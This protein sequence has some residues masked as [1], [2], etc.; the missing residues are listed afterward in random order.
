ML[1]GLIVVDPGGAIESANAAAA[2]IFGRELKDMIGRHVT[3][4]LG[5]GPPDRLE[6]LRAEIRAPGQNRVTEFE[7][8]R[9]GGEL[10]PV[11][12]SLFEFAT[13]EG[14]HYAAS[15]RDL[16]GRREVE[17]LKKEFVAT[18]SHE[19][20]TPLTS[21]RGSLGLLASGVLGQLSDEAREVVGIAE[22]NTLRLITLINEILDLERLEAGRIEIRLANVAVPTLVDRSCE[23]VRAFADAQGVALVHA[24]V[25][26]TMLG[27]EDRLVQVL[28]NLL[29]NAV[30][31][32]ARGGIVT[33]SSEEGPGW[34]ELRVSDG[35]RGIPPDRLQDIFERFQQLEAT[36][37]REKGGT[38]L[39]LAIAKAIVDLHHGEIGVASQV[40]RGSTF[41]FC[42]PAATPSAAAADPLLNSLGDLPADAGPEVLLV[43]DDVPLLGVMARQLL[44]AGLAVRTATTAR[45]AVGLARERAPSLLVLDLGLPDGDGRSVVEALRGDAKLADTPLLA[46][47]GRDMSPG[48]LEALRLGP[49]LALV[50]SRSS[51]AEFLGLVGRLLGRDGP[52]LERA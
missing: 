31:F 16:S 37:A 18:V 21:V 50:K 44:G 38:G 35:G 15:I 28:V 33:V 51:D 6:A 45:Q 30:K 1:E 5:P 19:L 12:L 52:S 32:S 41:H 4:L 43:D 49:T 13:A 36:D 46:Y 8:Q 9:A 34:V 22:R 11:E 14:R 39:G 20:R 29:S 7:A 17:R 26:G 2:R 24:G 42:I 47:T 48:Q 27:D 10:F 3:T 25:A 40:G 23:S